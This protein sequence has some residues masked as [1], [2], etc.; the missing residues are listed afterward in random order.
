M[1]HFEHW[2]ATGGREKLGSNFKALRVLEGF[3]TLAVRSST[4]GR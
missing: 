2:L 1:L 4:S 3:E